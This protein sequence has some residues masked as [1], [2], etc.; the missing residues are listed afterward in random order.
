MIHQQQEAE[1]ES[2]IEKRG[3]ELGKKEANI[4]VSKNTDTGT[5][6]K[7]ESEN[8]KNSEKLCTLEPN[9]NILP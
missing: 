5:S 9:I 8:G 1:E 7:N 3:N 4:S 2:T 6:D